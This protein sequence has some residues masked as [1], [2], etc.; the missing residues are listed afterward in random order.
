[1]DAG[2]LAVLVIVVALDSV[3]TVALV[4]LTLRDRR[5]RGIAGDRG[6]ASV[7][8]SAGASGAGPGRSEP[9][10]QG[11]PAPAQTTASAASTSVADDPLAGAI[12]A[13]LD[14]REGVFTAGVAGAPGQGEAP[15]VAQG[16]PPGARTGQEAG[17]T[18]VDEPAG[19]V[20]RWAPARPARYVAA[21]PPARPPGGA[22]AP[23]GRDP[24]LAAPAGPAPAGPPAAP[25]PAPA[26]ARYRP[27]SRLGVALVARDGP[28]PDTAAAVARL[29]PV[30]GGLL[31]E[32]TRARDRV[33]EEGPGRFVVV[34]PETHVDGAAALGIRLRTACDAWLAAE[35][36]PLRLELAATGLPGG[37]PGGFVEP[38]R[39]TG[40]ERRR[41]LGLET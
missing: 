18:G 21:G 5:T 28:E 25:L 9:D 12:S 26:A 32:R 2:L 23:A 40:P 29:G 13:F 17:G 37:V 39:A 41:P 27:A 8:R 14:R 38:A 11:A 4:V 1:M 10:G 30:I 34:L 35:S 3:A 20:V 31:R 7:A 24:A 6:A 19:P 33:A 36:P 22:P 16:A 15:G